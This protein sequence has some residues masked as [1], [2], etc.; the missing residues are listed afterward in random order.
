MADGGA[1]MNV[2]TQRDLNEKK[3]VPYSAEHIRRL[4]K[5]RLFP[6]PFK[7][8]PNGRNFWSEDEIDAWLAERKGSA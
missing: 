8:S 4:I 3:G 6:K 7:L 5:V 1:A 2:L